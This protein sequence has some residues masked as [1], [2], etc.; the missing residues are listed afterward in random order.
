MT[1]LKEGDKVEILPLRNYDS[2][3]ETGDKGF[4]TRMDPKERFAVKVLVKDRDPKKNWEST[5]FLKAI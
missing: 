3:N 5:K 2:A 1:K 4:I